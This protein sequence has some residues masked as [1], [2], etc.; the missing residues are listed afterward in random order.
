MWNI[1]GAFWVTWKVIIYQNMIQ[2]RKVFAARF[3]IKQT[4]NLKYEE[5]VISE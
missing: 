4:M 2:F 5:Q 3:C 1:Y